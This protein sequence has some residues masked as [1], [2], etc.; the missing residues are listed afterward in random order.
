MTPLGQCQSAL[1]VALNSA[2]DAIDAG[3]L[4]P[5]LGQ[6]VIDHTKEALAVA[7]LAELNFNEAGA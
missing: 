6:Q 7:V 3:A 4:T 1:H 5:E 2:L